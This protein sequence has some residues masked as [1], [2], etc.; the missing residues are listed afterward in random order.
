MG[1]TQKQQIAWTAVAGA[2]VG[3]IGLLSANSTKIFGQGEEVGTFKEKVIINSTA[4]VENGKSIKENSTKI[5][6][7]DI[8]AQVHRG[9]SLTMQRDMLKLQKHVDGAVELGNQR[10]ERILEKLND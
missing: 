10:F 1:K 4:I 9:E 6:K 2:I 7:I 3:I 5:T 8:E